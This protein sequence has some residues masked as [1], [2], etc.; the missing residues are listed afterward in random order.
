M[1]IE[2]KP[3]AK[4]LKDDYLFLID[5]MDSQRKPKLVEVLFE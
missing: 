4:D 1:D 2:I 3:L 5:I